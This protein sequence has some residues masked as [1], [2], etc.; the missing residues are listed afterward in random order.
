MVVIDILILIPNH[1]TAAAAFFSFHLQFLSYNFDIHQFERRILIGQLRSQGCQKL[2]SQK[3]CHGGDELR[4]NS[5]HFHNNGNRQRDGRCVAQMNF[6]GVIFVKGDNAGLHSTGRQF[7]NQIKVNHLVHFHHDAADRLDTEPNILGRIDDRCGA[8]ANRFGR[9]IHN[10]DVDIVFVEFRGEAGPGG[11][12]DAIV[13][14]LLANVGG[15]EHGEGVGE[16]DIGNDNSVRIRCLGGN[17][18]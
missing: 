11:A 18:R 16:C 9:E 2:L 10:I 5:L 3:L 13:R 4:T 1:Q 12:H 17:G 15:V 14:V 8:V 6:I 7:F